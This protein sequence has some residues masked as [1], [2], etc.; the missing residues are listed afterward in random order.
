MRGRASSSSP[1]RSTKRTWG[2]PFVHTVRLKFS[3]DEVRYQSEA[4]VG[5]GATKPAVLSGTAE[6]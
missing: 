5:F 2:T 6:K 3:G 1:V 4:N